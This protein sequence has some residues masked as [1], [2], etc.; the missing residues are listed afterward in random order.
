MGKH[1]EANACFQEVLKHKEEIGEYF[2]AAAFIEILQGNIEK[3]REYNLKREQANPAD[4]EIWYEITRIYGLL[5]QKTD[6]E[7][8][9]KKSI[10]LGYLNYPVMEKDVFLDTVRDESGIRNVLESAKAMHKDLRER[11]SEAA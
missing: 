9:L 1:D 5:N 3:A 2:F 4:G 6:C 8:A 10:E 11:L 7:R